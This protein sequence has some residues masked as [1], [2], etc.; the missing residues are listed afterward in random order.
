MINISKKEYYELIDKSVIL[1]ALLMQENGCLTN[2]LKK[3]IQ[4]MLKKFNIINLKYLRAE[5]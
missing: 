2:E 1:E 5:E 4:R 3:E